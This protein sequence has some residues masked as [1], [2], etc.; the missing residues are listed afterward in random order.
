MLAVG[1][2]HIADVRI[3]AVAIEI[4]FFLGITGRQPGVLH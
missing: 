3:D 2:V 4:N 1:L